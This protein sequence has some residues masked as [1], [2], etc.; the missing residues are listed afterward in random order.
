VKYGRKDII[1]VSLKKSLNK[2]LYSIVIGSA[3]ISV[4]GKSD[5]LQHSGHRGEPF[6]LKVPEWGANK[7]QCFCSGSRDNASGDI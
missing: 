5:G 4:S 7:Y 3:G 6:F 1:A 2:Y